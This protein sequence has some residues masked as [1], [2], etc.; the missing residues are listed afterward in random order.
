MNVDHR[1]SHPFEKITEHLH[2]AGENDQFDPI[3]MERRV[4]GSPLQV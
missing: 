1:A 3:F 2:V 4:D